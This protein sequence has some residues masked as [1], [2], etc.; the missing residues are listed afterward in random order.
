MAPHAIEKLKII[1]VPSKKLKIAND[2]PTRNKTILTPT[3][4]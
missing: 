3:P 2:N 4:K 1:G